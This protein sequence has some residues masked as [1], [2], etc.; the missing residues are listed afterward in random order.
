[1]SSGD[2]SQSISD[3]DAVHRPPPHDHRPLARIVRNSAINAVG[4]VLNLVLT[5]AAVFLLARRVGKEAFGLYFTIF[6]IAL[7]VYFVLESGISTV[8]TRRIA[9]DREG[10]VKHVSQANGLLLV[11]CVLAV[12]VMTVIGVGWSWWQAW[13]DQSD[14]SL[15]AGLALVPMFAAAGVACAMRVIMEF[16]AAVF[17]GLERFEYENIARVIQSGVFAAGIIFFVR[18]PVDTALYIGVAVLV[19]SNAASAVY[20][21]WALQRGWHCLGFELNSRVVRE[22]IPES[23]PLGVGDLVQRITWQVDTILL[24]QLRP[25]AEVGLYNIAYRPLQPLN[26]VPRTVLAVTF[27]G[28]SRLAHV[29]RPALGRAFATS[30]RLLWIVSLPIS[31]AVCAMA[32]PLVVVPAGPEYA[33]AVTPLRLLIWIV[34]LSFISTQFRFLFTAMDEQRTFTRLVVPILVLK[35]IAELALIPLFGYYGACLG[36]LLAEASLVAAGLWVLRA[37]GLGGLDWLRMA[38]AIPAGVAMAAPLW[39]LQGA[40]WPALMAATAIAGLLYFPLAIGCGAVSRDEI[41]KFAAAAKS[42]RRRK[43]SQRELSNVRSDQAITESE[44]IG[45]A[46]GI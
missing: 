24:G 37:H 18:P 8:L 42:M 14:D 12:L 19:V 45:A 15:L 5:F 32:E 7:V 46:E 29:D 11:V 39:W 25:M 26:L 34:N 31:I 2:D 41:A 33:D 16:Y 1:M 4:T 44:T 35:I 3:D 36:A 17:R 30:I 23:L 28:F 21:A 38:R 10:L 13:Y 20:I 6:T 43:Q 27:P 9:R 22:W 40:H